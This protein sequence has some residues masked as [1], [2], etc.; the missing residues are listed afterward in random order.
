MV[1]LKF[2]DVIQNGPNLKKMYEENGGRRTNLLCIIFDKQMSSSNYRF[3]ELHNDNGDKQISTRTYSI[4]S[5][6]NMNDYFDESD[7]VTNIL[8]NS[9]NTS[10]DKICEKLDIVNPRDNYNK[11]LNFEEI[12][13]GEVTLTN[14]ELT[15]E[16]VKCL[17][18]L[19]FYEKIFDEIFS[20][21]IEQ[22][23]VTEAVRKTRKKSK[24]IIAE[25]VLDTIDESTS[26]NKHGYYKLKYSAQDLAKAGVV[27]TTN[28]TS[29]YEI[30]TDNTFYNPIT[31]I[32]TD[33]FKKSVGNI[34]PNAEIISKWIN[35]QD[36]PISNIET[37]SVEKEIIAIEKG[38]KEMIEK[39]NVTKEKS[40]L[41][42]TQLEDYLW[43]LAKNKN[44][45]NE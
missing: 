1:K 40:K 34:T 28:E 16:L 26:I 35:P 12:N 30:Y 8:T 45:K 19:S 9:S 4:G 33:K 32:D 11:K 27:T 39:E 20:K 18:A 24:D 25:E 13:D 41:N 31:P 7:I 10:I 42:I 44:N 15:N 29:S 23:S 5:N 38:F 22:P 36:K 17:M 14:E 43:T 2:G 37:N 6:K 3:V 21:K